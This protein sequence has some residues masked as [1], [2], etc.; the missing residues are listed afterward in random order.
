KARFLQTLSF[1]SDAGIWGSGVCYHQHAQSPRGA[2]VGFGVC[3]LDEFLYSWLSPSCRGRLYG[4]ST[5]DTGRAQRRNDLLPL[6]GYRACRFSIS[7]GCRGPFIEAREMTLAELG[8]RR[9]STE[10]K[11]VATAIRRPKQRIGQETGACSRSKQ[12]TN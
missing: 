2:R 6:L 1:A 5:S 11:T 12:S 9:G 7:L 3:T 10:Y 8:K 4:Y